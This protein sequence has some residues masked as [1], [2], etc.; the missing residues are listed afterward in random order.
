MTLV[1]HI[2][3]KV[4]IANNDGVPL[5]K[6]IKHYCFIYGANLETKKQVA[7]FYGYTIK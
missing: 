7:E 5:D 2:I 3:R 1:K 6:A 4:V